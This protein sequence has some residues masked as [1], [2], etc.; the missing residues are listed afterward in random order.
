MGSS[1]STLSG[2]RE[3]YQRRLIGGNAIMKV[4]VFLII[5]ISCI[6]GACIHGSSLGTSTRSTS[7]ASTYRT[8]NQSCYG[9]TYLDHVANG[10][11]SIDQR[12]Y[13]FRICNVH[14]EFR[15]YI[16]QSP[17]YRNRATDGHSTHRH[18]DGQYY[19][20][21]SKPVTNYN[22]MVNIAKGW[23]DCTQKYIEYGT[24]F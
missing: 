23:A 4:L 14:G 5:A 6:I 21:W 18:Y 22:D 24:R 16:E 10:R 7:S 13:R 15:A 17:S 1:Y 9:T 19:V 20:C 8:S 3:T 11:S 12:R 2:N